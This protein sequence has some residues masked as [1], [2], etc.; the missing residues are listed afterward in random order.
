LSIFVS[1]D[2]LAVDEGR[3]GPDERDQVGCVDHAP[4]ALADSITLKAIARTAALDPWPFVTL[5]R[6]RT[7]AKVD[8]IGLVA[9]PNAH[10][11][12]EPQTALPEAA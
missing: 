10:P 7:V 3:P 12:P 11:Q 9:T 8:S 5:V 2:E 6:S 1:F 4:A